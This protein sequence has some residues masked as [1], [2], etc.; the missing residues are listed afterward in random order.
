MEPA[1]AEALAEVLVPEQWESLEWRLLNLYWIVDKSGKAVR[2]EPNDEQLDFIRNLHTR[3]LI[4]KARQKGFSTLVQLIQLD[5]ALFNT[6]HVGATIAETL[7]NAGKLFKKIEFA[8][9]KL[10]R[11]STRLNSSHRLTSR[12]PSS[13]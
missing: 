9:K 1:A 11:K 13:A 8:Q 3:N 7:P 6:H 4:L 12:M 5:Q 2:F 10:D